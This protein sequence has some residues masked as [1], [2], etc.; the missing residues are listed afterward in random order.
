MSL[1]ISS[2]V[3]AVCAVINPRMPT[4]T[5]SPRRF[6][7]PPRTEFIRIGVEAHALGNLTCQIGMQLISPLLCMRDVVRIAQHGEYGCL[8]PGQRRALELHRVAARHPSGAGHA[9]T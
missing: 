7:I 5:G 1:P 2:A 9:D 3:S 4:S 6:S 8:I